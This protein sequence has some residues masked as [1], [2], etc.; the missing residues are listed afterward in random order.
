MGAHAQP[1]V[2]SPPVRIRTGLHS[3]TSL[4]GLRTMRSP[5]VF[6][7]KERSAKR[8]DEKIS[9]RSDGKQKSRKKNKVRASSGPVK[10]QER[11]GRAKYRKS[12]KSVVKERI[13][14][15]LAANITTN[16]AEH[17]GNAKY[18]QTRIAE[19]DK[20]KWVRTLPPRLNFRSWR[21]SPGR[22]GI[23]SISPPILD[24]CL[25]RS[26]GFII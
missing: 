8:I 11:K 7:T 5:S 6:L 23:K 14:N 22:M 4:K 1:V 12:R 2:P 16:N 20:T 21:T 26:S 15:F 17:L 3:R 19:Q 13:R 24:Y 18:E 25:Q 9:V 10:C